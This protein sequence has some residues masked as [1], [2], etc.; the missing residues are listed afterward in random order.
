MDM[1]LL[2]YVYMG[3]ADSI[4]KDFLDRLVVPELR[5]IIV[6]LLIATFQLIICKRSII[7]CSCFQLV[8]ST[9]IS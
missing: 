4:E 8:I 1:L 6:S 5:S 9:S 3:A 7:L 2:K